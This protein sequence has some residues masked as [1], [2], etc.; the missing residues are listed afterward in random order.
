MI[1][2]EV[3]T[4][5]QIEQAAAPLILQMNQENPTLP[6]AERDKRAAKIKAQVLRGLVEQKLLENEIARLGIEVTDAEID[7]Y[8]ERIKQANG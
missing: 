4:L 5:Y 1:D 8:V 2:N 3:I 7:E 6:Q